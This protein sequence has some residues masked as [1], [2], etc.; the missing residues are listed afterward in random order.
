MIARLLPAACLL[1]LLLLGGC[2]SS[3]KRKLAPTPAPSTLP[4]RLVG[5]VAL[6]NEAYGFVLIDSNETLPAGTLL[7]TV[8]TAETGELKISTERRPPFLIGDIVN[9]AP[10]VGDLV[11]YNPPAPAAPEPPPEEAAAPE[12]APR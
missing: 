2:A 8:G 5:T 7:K 1:P 6:L 12:A 9:G 11:I 3:G 4:S 10:G